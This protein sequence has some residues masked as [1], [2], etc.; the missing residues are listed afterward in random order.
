MNSGE[1]KILL[2]V[3]CGLLLLVF[4]GC[5]GYPHYNVYSQ[6]LAGEARLREAESSR[7]IMVEEAKAKEQSAKLLAD[8]EVARARGVA[9]AN[10]IIGDSLKN[11]PEYLTWLWVEKVADNDNS[12]IY[13]P[14]E[15]GLPI[16]EAGRL[17]R[18]A[19]APPGKE[20]K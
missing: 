19:A 15:A 10:K 14:T 7:Q 3:V 11:N 6:R 2:G 4:G 13:V 18:K 16:L 1:V 9:E 12:V 5:Y 8:A 20:P 17:P